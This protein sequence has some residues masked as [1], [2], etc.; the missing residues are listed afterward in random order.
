VSGPHVRVFGCGETG[1]GRIR[2]DPAEGVGIACDVRRVSE[3]LSGQHR[4]VGRELKG[5]R[6]RRGGVR[7]F[8]DVECTRLARRGA[9]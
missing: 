9:R 1:G 6:C 3:G 8:I 7:S 2:A 4:V 5:K